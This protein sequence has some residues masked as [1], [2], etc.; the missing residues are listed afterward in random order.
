VFKEH[1]KM[2]VRG[3][4]K[5][6]GTIYKKDQGP[7]QALRRAKRRSGSTAQHSYFQHKTL[8]GKGVKERKKE[9]GTS[10]AS[11]YPF[12]RD[13]KRRHVGGKAG[14]SGFLKGLLQ[15]DEKMEECSMRCDKG[16]TLLATGWKHALKS[17]KRQDGRG[18]KEIS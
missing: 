11:I 14:K 12:D 16:L 13:H 3:M 5:R 15:K 6:E 1:E 7:S 9:I 10:S 2:S 17:G 4:I 8:S 18:G